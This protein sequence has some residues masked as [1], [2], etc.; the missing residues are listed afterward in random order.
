MAT[1]AQQSP[2]DAYLCKRYE[3]IRGSVF[4]Q[5]VRLVGDYL[6]FHEREMEQMGVRRAA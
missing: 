2:T 5:G 1:P 4:N 6:D 3:D